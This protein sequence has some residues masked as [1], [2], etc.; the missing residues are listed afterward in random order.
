MSYVGGIVK[1][2]DSIIWLLDLN[3]NRIKLQ[4]SKNVAA[5]YLLKKQ[6]QLTVSI[7]GLVWIPFSTQILASCSS[8]WKI[9]APNVWCT[10]PKY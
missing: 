5:V 6:T 1:C 2:H 10:Q 9:Q 3:I 7:Y 4:V 8:L